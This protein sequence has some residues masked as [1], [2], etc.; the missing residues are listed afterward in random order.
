MVGHLRPATESQ[1]RVGCVGWWSL[2]TG[3]SPEASRVGAARASPPV[4]CATW[5]L[6]SHH[7]CSFSTSAE[8]LTQ[9]HDSGGGRAG[10]RLWRLASTCIFSRL[11]SPS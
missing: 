11:Q 7:T 1:P 5:G 6:G 4:S 3:R 10:R 2:S 8:R 9:P